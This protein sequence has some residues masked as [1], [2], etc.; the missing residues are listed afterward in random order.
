MSFELNL[1]SLPNYIFYL[2]GVQLSYIKV[3]VHIFNLWYSNKPCFIGNKEFCN[4]TGLHKDTVINAIT[5]FEKNGELKRVYKGKRRYLVQKVRAIEMEE[6]DVDNS[7]TNR[8]ENDHG[9][10]LDRSTVGVRPSHESELDRYSNNKDNNKYKKSS[11]PTDEQKKARKAAN[12]KKPDYAEQKKAPLAPVENQTTSHDPNRPPSPKGSP[13]FEMILK[14]N[15][16][17]E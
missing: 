5:F 3:Y 6:D 9:S 10:E 2:E 4:R 11:C 15:V 17:N 16:K 1:A 13:L 12:E 7:P 14:K 8:S